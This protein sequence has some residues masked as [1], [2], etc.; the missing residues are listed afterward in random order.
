MFID[1]IELIGYLRLEHGHIDH[2]RI[3]FVEAMQ[4]VLGSNGS[5]KSSLLKE[6]SPLAADSDDYR[7]GGS[8]TVYITHNERKYVLQSSFQSGKRYSFVCDGE[9][10]NRG[11]TLTMYRELVFEHFG[12]NLEIHRVMTNEKSFTRM[13]KEERRAWFTMCS[14]ADYTYAIR[15]YQR[16]KDHHRDLQGSLKR[17][18]ERL[19]QEKSSTLGPEELANNRE[20]LRVIERLTRHYLS[21]R[22]DI[23]H[24]LTGA[25]KQLR[26]FES[27]HHR[28]RQEHVESITY[29]EN[30]IARFGSLEA[31]MRHVA[32]VKQRITEQQVEMRHLNQLASD[33]SHDLE[34]LQYK[35]V[36]SISE[37]ELRSSSHMFAIESLVAEIPTEIAALYRDCS[38]NEIQSLASYFR[39]PGTLLETLKHLSPDPDKTMTQASLQSLSEELATLTAG[40]TQAEYAVEDLQRQ[41]KELNE[42]RTH[43]PDITCPACEHQ[44]KYDVHQDRR[45]QQELLLKTQGESLARIRTRLTTVAHLHDECRTY[46]G[47]LNDVAN[48]MRSVP[49]ANCIWQH[50]ISNNMLRTNPQGLAGWLTLVAKC[51]ANELAIR[52]HRAEIQSIDG[53]KTSLHG[54]MGMTIQ[55]MELK[56]VG[57]ETSIHDLNAQIQRDL[58]R[59]SNIQRVLK[60][61]EFLTEWSARETE[62]KR[63]IT[64]ALDNV[65][66]ATANMLIDGWVYELDREKTRVETLVAKQSAQQAVIESL[67]Q[68]VVVLMDRIRIAKIAMTSMSPTDGLIA[69]GMTGFI[70]QF[71]DHMNRFMAKIWQYPIEIMEVHNTE[72]QV[73]LDY[74]FP[75]R[76]NHGKPKSDVE[77]G[78]SAMQEI[79]DLAFRVV[80]MAYLDIRTYPL[81]LDEFGAKFDKAHRDSAF[82]VVS[83]LNS[84]DFSQIFIVSH[85][86]QSY[87]ALR[88][89]GVVVLCPKNIEL[90]KG[91]LFNQHVL[92]N[93]L[94]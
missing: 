60:T 79:I 6:F 77:L 84:S 56:L 17:T 61:R 4:L 25:Y 74:K 21:L 81:F 63:Q 71:I 16:L 37:L 68:E 23:E 40:A 13:R 86:E 69:Q 2:I 88:N 53:L 50:V 66:H 1:A 44:F 12:I 15:F 90:P 34:T 14:Q 36:G 41:L 51:L 7:A 83:T 89:C 47:M 87:S 59:Q 76:T 45:K 30:Q 8:K 39:Q 32:T 10:L 58:K 91:T 20:L 11:F 29:V 72:G 43:A 82:H 52:G 54:E 73:D 3:N 24:D 65:D 27:E 26:A 94:D 62:L 92:I 31:F 46:V 22:K 19:V 67:E 75:F 35:K 70:N 9:E 5:G 18:N 78:S 28:L 38:D 55:D 85:H 93:A 42:H 33:L 80:S 64:T 48:Q 49:M 57:Y